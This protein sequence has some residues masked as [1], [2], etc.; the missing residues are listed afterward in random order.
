[1]PDRPTSLRQ[2]RQAVTSDAG[3]GLIESL[4]VVAVIAIL[5]GLG[6]AGYGGMTARTRVAG[7]GAALLHA[8]ELTRSEALKRGARVTLLPVDG[9]WRAGWTVLVDGNGNRRVDPGEPVLLRHARLHPS[10][11][12]VGDT[13]PGYIAFG[14]NGMPQ[15]YS[16]A[17]LAGTVALCDAGTARSVV[18]SRTGRPRLVAG[19]C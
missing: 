3:F 16:G 13:T 10:T 9:D 15:Q 6:A 19:T 14:G 17:F 1:M 2:R 8:V 12:L 7:D 4:I 18:L 11:R 5:G